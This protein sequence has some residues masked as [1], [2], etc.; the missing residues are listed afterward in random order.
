MFHPFFITMYSVL[1][2]VLNQWDDSYT[3]MQVRC[4][5]NGWVDVCDRRRGW[6]PL[7]AGQEAAGYLG[8]L[9]LGTVH[10]GA[11]YRRQLC[12]K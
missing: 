3:E 2:W 7:Q 12:W 11:G 1:C 5:G 10:I 4:G 6:R 8:G 9:V